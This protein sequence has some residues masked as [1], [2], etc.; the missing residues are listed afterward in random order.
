MHVCY[1]ERMLNLRHVEFDLLPQC[2][3]SARRVN[4]RRATGCPNKARNYSA[5][6]MISINSMLKI[7]GR[8]CWTPPRNRLSIDTHSARRLRV[9]FCSLGDRLS[10]IVFCE[11]SSAIFIR[12]QDERPRA[13]V[14]RLIILDSKRYL[15]GWI[16]RGPPRCRAIRKNRSRKKFR[17][18]RSINRRYFK[19]RSAQL[20]TTSLYFY[21][22]TAHRIVV[23]PIIAGVCVLYPRDPRADSSRRRNGPPRNRFTRTWPGTIVGTHSSD[24]AIEYRGFNRFV[25]IEYFFLYCSFRNSGLFACN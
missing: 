23:S 9:R 4:R 11:T 14:C 24:P 22:T 10:L 5:I 21:A 25:G 6:L 1:G 13:F 7:A 18:V 16:F 3:T 17:A 12:R 19:R 15:G 20:T 8:W 2:Y